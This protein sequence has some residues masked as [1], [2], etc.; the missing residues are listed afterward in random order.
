MEKKLMKIK[1]PE[2]YDVTIRD[3]YLQVVEIKQC[4]DGVIRVEKLVYSDDY[5]ALK[6]NRTKTL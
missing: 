1:I 3:G 2:N 4:K 6:L 5:P